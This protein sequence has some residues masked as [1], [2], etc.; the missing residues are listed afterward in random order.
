MVCFLQSF[1]GVQNYPRVIVVCSRE[2][3]SPMGYS[4]NDECE[5]V[6]K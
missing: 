2:N 4:L 6:F 5:C 3:V 1:S